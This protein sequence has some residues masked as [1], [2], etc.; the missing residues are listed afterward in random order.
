MSP[1]DRQVS[2]PANDTE[3]DCQ[4]RSQTSRCTPFFYCLPALHFF[5]GRN[6]MRLRHR[7]PIMQDVQTFFP[8]STYGVVC[9]CIH[10]I[11]LPFS[12]F[13]FY[14]V[15]T[16]WGSFNDY[17]DTVLPFF[18][19]HL[20]SSRHERGQKLAIFWPPTTSFCPRSHWMSP[21][22]E[23]DDLNRHAK[24]CSNLSCLCDLLVKFVYSEKATKF[25]EISTYFCLQYIQTEV[26][27]RFFK[28]LWPSQNIWTLISVFFGL[29]VLWNI[30]TFI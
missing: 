13:S 10:G 28:I 2:K 22:R 11:L 14:H 30:W 27:W 17:M 24:G 12:N 3:L 21:W 15:C 20:P 4:V 5:A 7:G 25:C 8:L 6:I 1:K 19:H 9:C 23:S 26:K 29:K 16:Y 18:D